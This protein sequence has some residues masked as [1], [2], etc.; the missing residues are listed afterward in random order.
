MSSTFYTKFKIPLVSGIIKS[1]CGHQ[2]V[3]VSLWCQAVRFD[4]CQVSPPDTIFDQPSNAGA[5]FLNS[6][7]AWLTTAWQSSISVGMCSSRSQRD[8]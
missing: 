4:W 1:F 2:T 3:R 7:R 6:V 8:T 5:I